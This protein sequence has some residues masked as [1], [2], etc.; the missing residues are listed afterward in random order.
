MESTMNTYDMTIETKFEEAMTKD[1]EFDSGDNSEIEKFTLAVL[2][3]QFGKTF[4][5]IEYMLNEI[6]RDREEGRSLHLVLTMNTFL[7]N[8]Q[9]ANR[10]QTIEDSYGKGSN[11]VFNSSKK[12]TKYKHVNNLE[13]LQGLCS[14]MSKKCPHTIIMCNNRRRTEDCFEFVN[15]LT[16]QETIKRVFIYYDEL[17]EYIDQGDLRA[18]IEHIHSYDI[19]KGMLATT[20]TPG[21]CFE[22]I[23]KRETGFWSK[24][25]TFKIKNFNDDTYVGHSDLKYILVDDSFPTPYVR[26]RGFGFQQL[27]EENLMHISL[28][29]RRYPSILENNTRSFIPAHRRRSGHIRVRDL[30]FDINQMAVVIVINST[31]KEMQFKN[32][33]GQTITVSMISRTGELCETIANKVIEYNL[34]SRPIVI[35]GFLCV[36]MGQTLTHPALGP[37]TSAIFGHMDL[38]NDD[39]YQLFGRVTGRMKAWETYVQTTVYC[40]SII[41]N[42]CGVMERSVRNII[43]NYNGQTVTREEYM[44]P[45]IEEKS[46]EENIRVP[47]VVGSKKKEKESI[48]DF[49]YRVLDSF[50]EARDFAGRKGN[51]LNNRSGYPETLLQKDGSLPT[52]EQLI[53]RKYGLTRKDVNNATD[54]EKK[55]NTL[56]AYKTNLNKWLVYWRPSF[57]N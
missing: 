49:D 45:I 36:S 5:T 47:K 17:H 54:K 1:E 8:E 10:L 21:N 52:M 40:P 7:N 37:F 22:K 30:I 32:E 16:R 50:E 4:L 46:T 25:R 24:I 38:T 28:I 34:Q 13:A 9:F 12:E 31:M 41:M 23:I 39:I 55:Q 19:L 43:E 53:T 26:P 33:T 42:R 20:A 57:F 29:L 27:E 48:S 35:T 11:C 3:P 18:Q 56:R 6:A 51:K 44:E 2:P 14:N 15:S